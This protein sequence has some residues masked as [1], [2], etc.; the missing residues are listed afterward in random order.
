WIFVWYAAVLQPLPGPRQSINVGNLFFL[1]NRGLMM[2]KPVF[3]E[4]AWLGLLGLAVAIAASIMIGRWARA[5]QE[6]TGEPF[7]VFWTA[8][9]LIV[10]LP[11]GGLAFAGFPI[12][13]DVPELKGFNF[14]G[15]LAVIPELIA[16]FLALSIYTGTYIAEA[17]RAGIQAVSHGQSEAA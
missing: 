3:G 15:G 16:L 9:T 1:S 6:A 8:I 2:P 11:L 13:W 17:V 4:G 10:L 14:A 5:R 7:P 12:S